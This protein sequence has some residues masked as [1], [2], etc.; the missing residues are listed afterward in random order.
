MGFAKRTLAMAV[1]GVLAVPQPAMA[2]TG[3]TVLVPGWLSLG[4]G[5]VGLLTAMILLVDA[6]LLRRVAEGSMIADN[7]VYMMLAVVCLGASVL[8]RF[9]LNIEQFAEVR[10]LVTLA[11]DL[12][13]T[14]GM[15]LLAAYFFRVRSAMTRYVQSAKAYQQAAAA[16]DKNEGDVSA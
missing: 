4:A 12:L 2:S 15:A 3:E 16:T 6:V 11:A 8:A 5:V 13:V 9:V 14:A 10:A 7:I 1:I